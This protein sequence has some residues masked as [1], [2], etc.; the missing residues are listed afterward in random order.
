MFTMNSLIPFVWGVN[1]VDLDRGGKLGALC[2]VRYVG[3][4]GWVR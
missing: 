2:W 3:G 1:M 4:L